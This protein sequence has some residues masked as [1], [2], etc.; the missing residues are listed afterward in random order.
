MTQLYHYLTYALVLL[1]SAACNLTPHSLDLSRRQGSSYANCG[2]H[3]SFDC[4]ACALHGE[5]RNQSPTGIYAVAKTIMTRAQGKTSNICRATRARHQFE[6]VPKKGRIRL[7]KNIYWA[8]K[9]ILKTKE[10]GWTHFW[11]PR[12][13]YQLGRRKPAWANTYDRQGCD[14]QTIGDHIFYNAKNCKN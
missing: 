4:M 9:K 1:T 6:G 10:K 12:S 2:A 11:A 14:R 7:T 3:R 13:Q 8:T 5:A